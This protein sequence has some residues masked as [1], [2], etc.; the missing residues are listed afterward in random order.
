M[1]TSEAND[2]ND[3]QLSNNAKRLINQFEHLRRD[4]LVTKIK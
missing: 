4:L 3:L 2:L 1:I